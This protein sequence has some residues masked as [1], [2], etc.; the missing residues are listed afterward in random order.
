MGELEVSISSVSK[1]FSLLVLGFFFCG[2]SADHYAR[3]AG[4]DVEALIKDREKQ[5]L[6]YAPQ[7]EA[8]L[9]V[10]KA[11]AKKAYDKLPTSPIP[12]RGPSAL[13]TEKVVVPR[14][15][16]GPDI[17]LLEGPAVEGAD[18]GAELA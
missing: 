15:P 4:L 2:C 1:F 6:D 11:V 16:L 17:K 13:E 10:A 12:P 8:P 9:P 14:E 18:W 7:V 5:T 3:Q